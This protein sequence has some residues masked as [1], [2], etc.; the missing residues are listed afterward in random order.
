MNATVDASVVR[1]L[2][3]GARAGDRERG[4]D[5]VRIGGRS[6]REGARAGGGSSVAD[7]AG[8]GKVSSQERSVGWR[9]EG[10]PPE[11]H[12]AGAVPSIKRYFLLD[13][14]QYMR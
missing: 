7:L 2:R 11:R 1:G 10:G 13:K 6:L 3:E 5:W 9:P 12:V 4:H 8:G 14:S